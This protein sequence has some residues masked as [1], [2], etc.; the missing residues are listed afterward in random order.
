MVIAC[1]FQRE[2][3]VTEVENNKNITIVNNNKNIK[4]IKL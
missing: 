3:L 4:M 1:R 2:D